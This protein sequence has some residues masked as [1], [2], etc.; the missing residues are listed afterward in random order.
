[1]MPQERQRQEREMAPSGERYAWEEEAQLSPV[2]PCSRSEL[3]TKRMVKWE[4][5]NIKTQPY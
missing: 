3:E 4:E 1:M 5:I 2:S